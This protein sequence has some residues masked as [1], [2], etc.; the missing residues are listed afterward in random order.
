[1]E[2]YE[3]KWRHMGGAAGPLGRRVSELA[4]IAGGRGVYYER[5]CLW[6]TA[7]TAPIEAALLEPP[8][9]GRAALVGTTGARIH[10]CEAD[11]APAVLDEMWRG[12]CFLVPVGKAGVSGAPKASLS[13]DVHAGG[14]KNHVTCVVPTDHKL[15][16]RT[17][18]DFCYT[19][20]DGTMQE[21]S[22][23]AVYAR[24][25]YENCAFTHVTDIHVSRRLDGVT[26]KLKKE[27][28]HDGAASFNNF[29]DMFRDFVRYANA[30]HD[31]GDLDFVLATGDL[32]DYVYEDEDRRGG[33]GNFALLRDMI[34]GRSPYPDG[35]RRAEELRL[36][37]FTVLG[38]HDYR[39]NAYPFALRISAA[40][41]GIKDV[42]QFSAL[43]LTEK[44]AE[45]VFGRAEVS[46]T[47][48]DRFLEIDKGMRQ[49]TSYYFERINRAGSYLIKAGPHRI[50]MIDSRWD[51]GMPD[52][53][54]DAIGGAL[55]F[56]GEDVR[57]LLGGGPNSVGPQDSD[58]D[59]LKL[60]IREAGRE[61][62]VVLGIHAPL[63]N[64]AGNEYAHYFR[65]SE[66]A[67]ADPDEVKA[68]LVRHGGAG[69]LMG[70]PG[71]GSLPDSFKPAWTRTGTRHFK[72][73]SPGDLLD[74]GVSRGAAEELLNVCAGRGVPRPAD[75]ALFG[76]VHRNVEYRV[77]YDPS[78]GELRYYHDYYL[79]D[80]DEYYPSR[81]VGAALT[82]AEDV[83]VRVR[84]DAKPGGRPVEV[85]DQR[86]GAEFK[87]LDVPS[88]ANALATAKHAEGWWS[89]NA[90]VLAQ[91]GPLGP[92][93]NSR[94]THRKG[95]PPKPMFQGFRMFAIEKNAIARSAYVRASAMRGLYKSPWAKPAGA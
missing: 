74:K 48:A 11:I 5:G 73:G 30:M 72:T 37:I 55:G 91:T 28:L 9:L 82:V 26:E 76:H 69:M 67:A 92:V 2:R 32:V 51:A 35:D 79:S 89:T 27:G 77:R 25:S 41:V 19:A 71:S 56:G 44:E 65:E 54:L 4:S 8:L 17:L 86:T 90:P 36:P 18:Y 85:R 3:R 20:P 80:L 87:R 46:V 1:M 60:A 40:G 24:S 64:I 93:D 38:N 6:S 66:H 47:N 43:N 15:R 23:H 88:C 68:F 62:T 45:A 22:P 16:E 10:V 53:L 12:R 78:K 75:L 39:A 50:V 13:L 7:P 33:P 70:A 42:N 83:A 52:G 61:G 31:A 57:A 95:S 21:V 59:L 29:N 63:V 84:T 81:K 14:G 58:V 49:K 94:R 34:L